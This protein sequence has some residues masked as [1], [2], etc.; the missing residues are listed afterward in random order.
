M[1]LVIFLIV[2]GLIWTLIG[3]TGNY[4]FEKKSKKRYERLKTEKQSKD[5]LLNRKR[6]INNLKTPIEVDGYYPTICYPENEEIYNYSTDLY[7]INP[8]FSKTELYDFEVIKGSSENY[9]SFYLNNY[10]N[11]DLITNNKYQ[12]K[13]G[14][15]YYV[16]DFAYM[17]KEKKVLIDIEIDEPYT[18]M[19]KKIIHYSYSDQYRNKY[20]QRAGWAVIRFSEKQIYEQPQSCCKFISEYLAYATID[21]SYLNNFLEIPDLKLDKKWSYEEGKMY[22]STNYRNKYINRTVSP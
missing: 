21:N 13:R 1:E 16:P 15:S 5:S 12:I 7:Y 18:Y 19:E 3:K 4:F 22:A 14:N 9:F 20:F 10:L 2:I 6:K 17:D 8:E 11:S